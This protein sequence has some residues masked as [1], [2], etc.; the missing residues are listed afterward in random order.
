VTPNLTLKPGLRYDRVEYRTD[1]GERIAI[2]DELQPRLGFAWDITGDARNVVRASWGRYMDP[3]ALTLPSFARSI[4]EPV[5]IWLSCSG[6]LDSPTA[7]D[8]AAFAESRGWEYG[9]DH[10]GWDPN[11]WVHPPGNGSF[12]EP[13]LVV[14]DLRATHADELILAYEREVG[15]RSSVELTF[16]DKK[17]RDIFEDTCNV[18]WPTPTESS[19]CDHAVMANLP[20]ARRDYR[21]FIVRFESRGFGWLTLLAS[22]TYSQSEGS[23]EYTQN[24]GEDFDYYPWH[25]DNRYGYLSDHQAHRVKLNGYVSLGG[26]WTVSFD[27]YWSSPWTWTPIENWWFNPEMPPGVSSHFLEPRGSRDG[28]NY[29]RLDLQL[30]KGFT[31]DRFRLVLIGSVL[32]ALSS[33][34]VAGVCP[35]V[36]GCGNLELGEPYAWQ[37]PRRW[38]LGFRLEF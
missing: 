17:T 2:L 3:N 37:L 16:V 11:G 22:Y 1:T 18:N 32:N 5:F 7:E 36:G 9:T 30:A 27:G 21:A 33:E 15:H 20:E 12:P 8:C 25:Y 6:Y 26:D 10:E 13:N 35:D 34:S 23:V 29:H 38:E 28:E 14:P 19:E 4:E 31:I 24:V